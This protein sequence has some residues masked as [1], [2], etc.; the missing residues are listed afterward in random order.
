MERYLKV[1]LGIFY[2]PNGK[3]KEATSKRF[4]FPVK[5]S[6]ASHLIYDVNDRDET[7]IA[8]D[9]MDFIEIDLTK[10]LQTLLDSIVKRFGSKYNGIQL[11]IILSELKNYDETM[12]E[13]IDSTNSYFVKLNVS[14]VKYIESKDIIRM[15]L[16]PEGGQLADLSVYN[17]AMDDSFD[18]DDD[19]I[20]EKPKSKCHK[21][22]VVVDDEKCDLLASKVFNNY[23][24]KKVS[25][26]Y[27][28]YGRL[29]SAN[30]E[31]VKHDTKLIED[32]LDDFINS[33]SKT[34][35]KMKK[36][37]LTLWI[38]SFVQLIDI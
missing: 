2:V 31:D 30:K 33:D 15:F 37:L 26:I 10:F 24:D 1:L 34:A 13:F 6:D 25:E 36:K 20:D 16:P 18:Y 27:G 28:K 22:V 38:N 17:Q 7:L 8:F 21:K 23:S 14:A 29:V 9:L 11:Q 19:E 3:T 4:G 35:K 32:F 5:F 12:R